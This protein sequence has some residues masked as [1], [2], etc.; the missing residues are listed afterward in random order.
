MEKS[1]RKLTPEEEDVIVAKGTERPFTGKYYT[2]KEA[3]TYACKRCGAALYR[4]DDKFDS[5]C[6]WPSF[7]DELP[8]VVK[9]QTD[10]DGRR[11]E[12]MCANCGAH[13]G[14]VFMGEEQTPK[15]V[16]HCVNSISLD[17]IPAINIRKAYFSGG[18]F[19]GVESCMRRA[20]GVLG[21]RVG[22]MGG[23]TTNPTYEEVC[24]GRTGHAETVFVEYDASKADYET[25]VK[26]FFEIHDPEQEDRQG[27]DVGSQYRSAIFYTDQSQKAVA[28]KVMDELKKKGINAV[29]EIRS[30]GEFYLAEEYHQKYFEKTGAA[31]HCNTRKKIF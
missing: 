31:P 22:Y 26:L 20:Q 19:W 21:T 11:T 9:R 10:P 8:G 17:F 13:L 7:D 2:Y 29:T 1:Y 28:E 23:S 30:A 4:S 6:G 27:P 24:T 18:C 25:L 3:G 12:I 16:R 14:H 5:G 15:D